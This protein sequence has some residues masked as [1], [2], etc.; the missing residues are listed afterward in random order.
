MRAMFHENLLKNSLWPYSKKWIQGG[1]QSL[2]VLLENLKV[3]LESDII[4]FSQGNIQL[5]NGNLINLN[6]FWGKA[7][8]NKLWPLLYKKAELDLRLTKQFLCVAGQFPGN[9]IARS[10]EGVHV[11]LLQGPVHQQLYRDPGVPNPARNCS[12]TPHGC[13]LSRL[14][15]QVELY[16]KE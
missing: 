5:F 12:R 14:L 11:L 7:L 9:S 8:V 10:T 4:F 15:D 6:C 16:L 3:L 2:Q 13:K 1:K